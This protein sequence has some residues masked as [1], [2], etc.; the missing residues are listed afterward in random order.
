MADAFAGT[1][2]QTVIRIVF[3]TNPPDTFN[4]CREFPTLSPSVTC[5]F[6]GWTAEIV[7]MLA[8]YLKW[9]IEP[10]MLS[11]GVNQVDWGAN[12]DGNWT[13]VL[14]MLEKR[15]VDTACLL[16]Q[17]TD[18]RFNAFDYSYPV[19]EIQN[20]FFTRSR[21]KEVKV[22]MWSA[23][24]PYKSF[25]WTVIILAFFA[26]V[27]LGMLTTRLE[28]NLRMRRVL[29]PTDK[30]WQYMRLHMQQTTELKIPFRLVAGN[31]SFLL[32]ILLQAALFTK[33]YTSVF[34]SVLYHG[35]GPRP[36]DNFEQM[37]HLVEKGEY[38]VIVDRNTYERNWYFKE[39][40][41]SNMSRFRAVHDALQKNPIVVT[42]TIEEALDRIE[43]GGYIFAT[44]EDSV[45]MQLSKERCNI[46]YF[47][48]E[49]SQRPAFFL[50]PHDN[51]L[52]NEWNRAIRENDAFIRRTYMKYFQLGYKT[53]RLPKCPIT[54]EDI[55][56]AA[57]P[58]DI[59]STFGTFLI[60]IIGMTTA[61]LA[62]ALEHYVHEH[63]N[64]DRFSYAMEN[65]LERV[66]ELCQ[67]VV[68]M[69]RAVARRAHR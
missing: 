5:P 56:E 46:F 10:V 57:K 33:L 4:L 59:M 30:L 51:P 11:G 68:D 62:F 36:W 14:S 35:Q 49:E 44:Q 55:P 24:W 15:Q 48:D 6:P 9:K 69:V 8:D 52:A 65:M 58:L 28:W 50:F 16:F 31:L 17:F 47:T 41:V 39:L 40:N 67:I 21:R 53:G 18:E 42:E 45:A 60:I 12:K 25:A 34:L 20:V 37:V 23:F 26:Q 27:G 66:M 32:Y 43:E 19:Y 7:Q 63:G 61:T 29:R 38:K 64:S 22:A 13:G 54:K 1:L 3:G 2:S